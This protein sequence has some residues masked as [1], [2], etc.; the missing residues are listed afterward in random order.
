MTDPLSHSTLR[1]LAALDPSTREPRLRA[2]ALD[3][4][5]EP[6]VRAAAIALLA[7]DGIVTEPAQLE[8]AASPLVVSAA[9]EARELQRG[10]ALVET[11]LS[12]QDIPSAIFDV[13][14][15]PAHSSRAVDVEA[16]TV[17]ERRALELVDAEDSQ[18]LPA[19]PH[20]VPLITVGRCQLAVMVASTVEPDRLLAAPARPARIAT[21]DLLDDTPWSVT[22]DVIT[23]PHRDAVALA[24]IDR[25]GRTRYVGSG[26][27]VPGALELV[28]LPADLPATH[29]VQ[30]SAVLERGRLTITRAEIGDE[31]GPRLVPP[32]LPS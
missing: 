23:A 5:A 25:R 14:V 15:M 10:R 27:A 7:H 19:P 32:P 9:A 4:R 30:I 2:L 22:L 29:P 20:E 11:A 12:H 1:G 3:P 17:E 8:T 31:P 16:A 24:A 13:A 18:P 6:I 28:A 21:R 26:T